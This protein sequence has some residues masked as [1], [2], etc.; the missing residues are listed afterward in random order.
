V[1][2]T[3]L[4]VSSELVAVTYDAHDPARLAAFWAGLLGREVVDVPGGALLVGEQGEAGLE[5]VAAETDKTG[6]GRFH[7][8]LTS[9]GARDQQRT[10]EEALRLGARHLDVGQLLEEGH[11]VLADPE[12]NEFCVIEPGNG[13]LAGCGVLGEVSGDGTRAVGLFWHE[14]LGWP[15]VWDQD[16]ETAVQSPRGGTK[17]SWGGPPVAAKHGRNRQRL[18]LAATDPD[19]EVARL[20]ALGATEIGRVLDSVELADPD[21]NEFLLTSR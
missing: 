12:G 13:F 5:L 11:V 21:G 3:V 17:I 9:D 19:A 10:V 7:L 2:P 8:H 15:L 6:P 18:H 20:V 16:E 1:L 4:D 14:A